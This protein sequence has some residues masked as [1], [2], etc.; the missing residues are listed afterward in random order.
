LLEAFGAA[1]SSGLSPIGHFLD[2]DT[3]SSLQ[4]EDVD[5]HQRYQEQWVSKFFQIFSDS[6]RCG[7]LQR[8]AADFSLPH[9]GGQHSFPFDSQS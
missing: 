7:I 6:E 8:T 2:A 5:T 4:A 9:S 3:S 1:V